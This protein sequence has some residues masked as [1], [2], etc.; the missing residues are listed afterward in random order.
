MQEFYSL[1]DWTQDEV[2]T[3]L[4]PYINGEKPVHAF[5]ALLNEKP[6]GYIQYYQ[7]SDFP[8]PSV[9]IPEEILSMA[10]GLDLF[11]GEENLL[12]QGLGRR[13]IQTFLDAKIWPHYEF[14]VVDPHV[15]NAAAIQCYEKLSFS[16]LF[17]I[18]SQDA[19]GRMAKL[20]LLV[21]KRS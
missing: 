20:Q 11:I 17:V 8:W 12:K 14:C 21:L 13:I 5:I 1:R 7:V 15:N 16:K 6:I 10:A 18:K 19:L 2:M 3:K 4:K 9:N